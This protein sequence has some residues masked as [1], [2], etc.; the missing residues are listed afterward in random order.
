MDIHGNGYVIPSGFNLENNDMVHVQLFLT[1]NP[2]PIR[3]AKLALPTD[4]SSR[5]LVPVKNIDG[6]E[7]KLHAW[8]STKGTKKP[9]LVNRLVD[10]LE[11][12]TLQESWALQRRTFR[13]TIKWSRKTGTQERK[14]V[15]T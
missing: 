14:T 9:M 7:K 4:P 10:M 12:L 5:L 13:K 11:G 6:A 8:L 3:Y 15:R 1:D 2:N